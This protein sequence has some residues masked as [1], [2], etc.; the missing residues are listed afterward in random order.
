MTGPIITA[1]LLLAAAPGGTAL[2]PAAA[3]A[4]SAPTPAVAQAKLVR[5]ALTTTAGVITSRAR[6]HPCA[7]HHRQFPALCDRAPV[8]RHQLLPGR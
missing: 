4:T 8:R 1:L 7:D 5:V 6:Q 2:A 3:P